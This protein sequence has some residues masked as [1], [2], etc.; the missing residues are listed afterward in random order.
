MRRDEV[1]ACYERAAG[2][3]LH[4]L[5]WHELFALTRSVAVAER[6]SIV[7]ALGG[8]EYPGGGGN[9]DPVLRE[10]ARRIDGYEG[11]APAG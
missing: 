9:D 5:G 7:A 8:I 10:L 1:I 2:R 11:E 6:L 4:D 3:E